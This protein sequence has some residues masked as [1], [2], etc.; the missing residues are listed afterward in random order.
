LNGFYGEAA[1]RAGERQDCFQ[2]HWMDSSSPGWR[3]PGQYTGLSIPLNGFSSETSPHGIPHP[4]VLSIPLNGFTTILRASRRSREAFNSI[5][6]IPDSRHSVS[7]GALMTE[8]TF[9]SIEWIRQPPP[10]ARSLSASSRAFN[11]IEWIRY[12]HR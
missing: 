3:S 12:Q 1:Q 7:E 6:W 11:S 4:Q 5:E 9:N 8:L 10:P 2:F